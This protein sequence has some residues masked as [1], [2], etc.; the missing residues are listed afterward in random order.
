MA[1][2]RITEEDA[3]VVEELIRLARQLKVGGYLSVFTE[4]TANGDVLLEHIAAEKALIRGAA[5]AE[6]A[7]DPIKNMDPNQI[8][9]IR[10]NLVYL[11]GPLL[12]ALAKTDPKNAP[13]VSM[14]GALKYLGDPGVQK[15]LGF[16]LT[17]A[18]NLGQA[19]DEYEA[20]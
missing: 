20:K 13:K 18:K 7:M 12:E 17:L 8:P 15:G 11:I 4:M 9:K 3:K 16:L 19:M 6:A 10:H 2:V 14:F 5:L 1:E